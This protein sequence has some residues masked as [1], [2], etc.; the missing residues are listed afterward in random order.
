MKAKRIALVPD[1]PDW[2]WHYMAQGLQR[3]QPPGIECDI[4]MPAEMTAESSE[5]YDAVLQ[6]SWAEA[7]TRLPV[8]NVA[9]VASHACE[10][11]PW[12][13]VWNGKPPSIDGEDWRAAV[14]SRISNKLSAAKRF[15]TFDGL[16]CV[17]KP[18]ERIARSVRGVR[19][20]LCAPPGV[21]HQFWERTYPRDCTGG[22]RVGWCGQYN[23]AKPDVK[24][25]TAVLE[26]LM[27]A[28]G[29][30]VEWVLN[31]RR[32]GDAL[33]RNEM[34]AW[35]QEIDVLLVTSI[36]EG[37]PM[38][39]LEAMS[40][41]RPV[42]GTDVGDLPNVIMPNLTGVLLG[43]YRDA[44]SAG[45]VVDRA[46]RVIRHL[47]ANRDLLGPMGVAAREMIVQRR[48]WKDLAPLWLRFVAG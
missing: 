19:R 24:G 27:E 1:R 17:S 36:S 40:C 5:A 3:R 10:H 45:L 33:S 16:I 11:E 47:A 25:V 2:A 48:T 15:K 26:P 43:V 30:E 18:L 46:V 39:A 38:P 9:V 42:I 6:F 14:A 21:D 7:N 41:G 8:R 31:M 35:Y 4:L 37:T 20:V 12:R 32:P 22:L 28:L 29:D 44:A 23:S 13:S 34:R